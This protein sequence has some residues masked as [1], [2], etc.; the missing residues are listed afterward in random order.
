M[1]VTL[2][3]MFECYDEEPSAKIPYGRKRK[4]TNPRNI[5]RRTESTWDGPPTL[6]DFEYISEF[7]VSISR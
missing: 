6:L 4:A 5:E 2:K 7:L 3:T 1:K